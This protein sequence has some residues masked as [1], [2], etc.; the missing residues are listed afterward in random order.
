MFED[1]S[2][3]ELKNTSDMS[4]MKIFRAVKFDKTCYQSQLT[5]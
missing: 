2:E 3:R 4:L 5:P 1:G